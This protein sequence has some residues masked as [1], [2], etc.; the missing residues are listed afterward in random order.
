MKKEHE[1]FLKGINLVPR[2][3]DPFG[4]RQGSG[5]LANRFQ[6]QFLLAV[7]R[8]KHNNRKSRKSTTWQNLRKHQQ[9]Q[10]P[11]CVEHATKT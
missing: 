10:R 9:K 8:Q 1:R 11:R 2:R 3:R 6:G 5:P 7:E 4:Q